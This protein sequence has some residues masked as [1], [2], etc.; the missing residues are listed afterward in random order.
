MLNIAAVANLRDKLRG[1]LLT[2]DAPDYDATRKVFNGMVNKHPALIARCTS[3]SDVVACVNFARDHDVL[4]SVRGGGHNFAGNAVCDGGLMLDFT[5]MKA[6]TV[7]PTR[8]VARAQEDSILA[9]SIARLRN[10]DSRQPSEWPR[11]LESPG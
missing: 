5:L 6:I 9:N 10:S 7:D 8:R 3:P 11:P 1:P 2:P 4:L